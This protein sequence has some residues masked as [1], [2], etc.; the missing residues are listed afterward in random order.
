MVQLVHIG[1]GAD[2]QIEATADRFDIDPAVVADSPF[3]LMGS[4]EAVVDKLERLRQDIGISHVVVRDAEAFAP[5]VDA[6][7]GR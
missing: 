7:A 1:A 2:E 4:V 6:L 5:V 3:L